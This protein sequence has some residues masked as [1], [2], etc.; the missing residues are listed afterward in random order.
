MIHGDTLPT[1]DAPRVR[2]R[3][4]TQA[5]ASALFDVFSHPEVAR[6]LSRPA[7]TDM[8]PAVRLIDEIHASFARRDLFQ[9]GIARREDDRVIGTCTLKDLDA[10]HRR[11]ELGYALGRDSWGTG[12]AREAIHRVVGFAFDELELHRLEADVDPRNR[13]SIRSLEQE[14]FTREGHLRERWHVNGEVCDG[15]FYGLLRREWQR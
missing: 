4:I 9:W 14:G 11:A 10:T 8:G 13:R 5:D 12:I 3:W 6:Y 15:L 2:L 1:L 7:W